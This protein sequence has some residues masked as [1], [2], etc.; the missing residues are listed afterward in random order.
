MQNV[1]DVFAVILGGGRGTRL[2]PLTQT[3]AKP[4]IPI[5]GDYRL[6]DVPISNCINSGIQRIAVLTQSNSDSVHHH[7]ARAYNMGKNRHWVKVLPGA[8]TSECAGWY[9]GTAD[10]VRKRLPEIQEAGAEYT[11]ILSG[12]HLYRMDYGEMAEFHRRRHADLTLAVQPVA[13][14]EASRFG[15]LKRAPNGRIS[16]FV[17]KPHSPELQKQFICRDDPEKPFLGSMGIYMFSTKVLMDVLTDHPDC[18]DFGGDIIPQA[19]PSR[20]VYGYVFDG[21]WQD[22][23]TVRSFYET[24]L[25]L[26]TAS[27]P[28]KFEFP[29][30]PIHTATLTLP[31]AVIVNSKLKDVIIARGCN[32]SNAGIEH[33]V[34]GAGSQ[35]ADGATVKHS[36]V[37]GADDYPSDGIGANCYVE[38]AILDKNVRLGQG[39]II[40]PFPRDFRMDG[41]DWVVRDGI[42]V[43]PRGAGI[44]AGSFIVP[45]AFHFSARALRNV[46]G[47]PLV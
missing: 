3:R 45:E 29:G 35:I 27:A 31:P 30:S 21:Y 2:H 20:R 11:L 8:Q 28:F 44:A 18:D 38:G 16:N 47:L 36:V 1:H 13:R 34:I 4:A 46:N 6:I 37:L 41:P 7:I 40:R 23:G 33:S 9:R 32:I 24:N 39:V 22:V 5:A 15:I 26:T 10:A 25:A 42:V 12:D 19:I 17:E 14:S 43:I